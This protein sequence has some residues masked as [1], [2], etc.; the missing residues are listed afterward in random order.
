MSTAVYTSS[1]TLHMRK[2]RML[3]L[4]GPSGR[5]SQGGWFW[6]WK[7]LDISVCHVQSCNLLLRYIVK[8]DRV[9]NG[10]HQKRVEAFE[11]RIRV[12]YGRHR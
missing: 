7:L 10:Q 3:S 9:E 5:G 1:M 11:Q 6:N 2:V 8:R 12:T 4:L